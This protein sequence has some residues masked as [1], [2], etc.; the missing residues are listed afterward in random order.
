LHVVE[1]DVAEF[2]LKMFIYWFDG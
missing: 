1:D 2:G